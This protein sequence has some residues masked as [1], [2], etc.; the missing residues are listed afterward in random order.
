MRS[1]A[2]ILLFVGIF[3]GSAQGQPSDTTDL[4]AADTSTTAEEQTADWLLLPFASYAPATKI[5]GGLVVGYYL[6]ARPGRSP[7]SVELTL[8]GTQRRQ[9]TAQIEPELYVGDGRWRVQGE[10]LASKFPNF[11]YDIGGDTHLAA[12]ESYTARYGLIDLAAQHRLGPNLRVGPRVFVR[13]GTVTDPDPDG[14]IGRGLVPGADGGENA[15]LGLSALWDAR[16]NIYY[17][18]AGTYAETVA[19]WH[20]AAW[21]SDHTFGHLTADLRGYRSTGAGVVAAQAYAEAIVGRAPF[22]LLPLLG[23]ADRMRGYR[24]G[25]F[26][27]K[28]YWTLQ[29]EYRRPLFWRI[30]GTVF[31]S[32]GEVGPRIGPSLFNEIEAAVGAGGRFRFTDNGVHGRLDVAYSRTGIELYISL[33]EAF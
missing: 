8:K 1:I 27:D 5:A 26:R 32:V 21:G 16:D 11:F 30:K 17:P 10:L 33:G 18:R 24:E 15:G 31:A 29:T 22:Q 20:S 4:S 7:S 19:T 28:V 12:K 9:F 13:V 23:G 25:R 2:S 6:P 3:A 14:L